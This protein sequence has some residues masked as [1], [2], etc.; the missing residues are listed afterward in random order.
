MVDGG[1]NV[2]VMGDLGILL[3]VVS[4]N[5]IVISVALDGTLSP[6]MISLPREAIFLSPSWMA[7]T[8]IKHVSTAPTW[9][10][11]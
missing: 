5:L 10:K 9:S 11:Q 2:C 4:I 8:I 1:S 3:D 7:P 6:P